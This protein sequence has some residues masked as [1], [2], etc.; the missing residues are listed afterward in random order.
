VPYNILGF[1][2]LNNPPGLLFLA[3]SMQQPLIGIKAICLEE[4]R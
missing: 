4:E 1:K 2:Q 3:Q